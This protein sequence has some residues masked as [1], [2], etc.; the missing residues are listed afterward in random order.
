MNKINIATITILLLPFVAF[1]QWRQVYKIETTNN[2]YWRVV[3]CIMD[4]RV[5]MHSSKNEVF[6]NTF[7]ME[8]I[9]D[10]TGQLLA[11]P[12]SSRALSY[13][14][15]QHFLIKY[16]DDKYN[17]SK[18]ESEVKVGKRSNTEYYR[19]GYQKLNNSFGA[20]PKCISDLCMQVIK[21]TYSSSRKGEHENFNIRIHFE[22]NTA[23]PDYSLNIYLVK[24]GLKNIIVIDG[25]YGEKT[26]NDKYIH[27]TATI[28]MT[29]NRINK[30]VKKSRKNKELQIKKRESEKLYKIESHFF[31]HIYYVEEMIAKSQ[32]QY[33]EGL[34]PKEVHQQIKDMVILA[35][36]PE[37][38]WLFDSF[39]LK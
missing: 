14:S 30:K 29:L 20:R 32:N 11:Y 15:A 6:K 2:Y 31:D 13:D 7:N 25:E 8:P 3:N 28:R 34:I 19:N 33:E 9:S 39:E 26:R 1:G 10:Y 36:S 5:L 35:F 24:F 21:K 18:W 23:K 22:N 38:F 37:L 17:F 4:D 12:D 16:F 27:D